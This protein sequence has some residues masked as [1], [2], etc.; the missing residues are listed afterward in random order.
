MHDSIDFKDSTRL[1]CTR[2][3]V[4]EHN[5]QALT[6]L[7]RPIALIK[8]IHNNKAAEK[9]TSDEASGIERSS[10][11]AIGAKVMLRCN[12]S[13]D[14]GLV[15]GTIGEVHNIL[16][17][18]ENKDLPAVVICV[19]PQYNGPP[20]LAEVPHSFPV[21]PVQR[22]WTNDGSTFLSRTG[23]PLTLAFAITVH[24]SQGLTLPK[25]VIDL[26]EHEI[27]P[28]LSF[29][30]LSRVRNL[31][32]L[33]LAPFDY[34]RLSKLHDLPQLIDRKQEEERLQSLTFT[35]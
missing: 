11:L 8:S 14:L 27:T 16:Y 21:T 5:L 32:D 10:A 23:L 2:A 15:N 19:F 9:A 26:G 28:G 34:S 25:A 33:L 24:K 12:L 1:F 18:P 30:A 17:S 35:S 31:T 6:D 13:I 22:T 20:F 29:V 4:K 3:S 7:K